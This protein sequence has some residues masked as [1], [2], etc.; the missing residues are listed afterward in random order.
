V[1][2]RPL[3]AL[4]AVLAVFAVPTGAAF[5][6]NFNQA[7]VFGDSSVDSG[8]YK[9]VF[10]NPGGGANFNILWAAAVAAGAGEPTSSPGLMNSEALAAF[11]GLTALP[12]NQSGGTN[13]ATSG[14][15]SAQANA[16]G[17]ELFQAAVPM[18]TQISNYLAAVGGRA[19]ANALYLISGGGNDIAFAENQSRSIANFPIFP[20]GSAA[21][22][23]YIVNQ[24][25]LL[26]ASIAQLKA[27]GA[28]Y[29]LAAPATRTRELIDY[30]I[31]RPCGRAWQRQA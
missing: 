7:I 26:V 9:N 15:R 17:E 22:D 30:S 27:A 5:A 21:A 19:N 23:T 28:R 24:A 16:A 12:S 31:A 11:F 4:V 25:N 14:A 29:I 20:L 13:Y 18:T 3:A 8:Y 1:L 6:Q 10:P 2:S